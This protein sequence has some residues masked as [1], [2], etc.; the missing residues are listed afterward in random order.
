MTVSMPIFSW[1]N[2]RIA[3]DICHSSRFALLAAMLLPLCL[4]WHH[5][6]LLL[7]PAGLCLWWLGAG[8]AGVYVCVGG[9]LAGY[10]GSLW[11]D[12]Q[13]PSECY[14]REV[15]VAGQVV[16]FVREVPRPSGPPGQSFILKLHSPVPGCGSPNR[17][18]V[19]VTGD[20][21]DLQP[22]NLLTLR[23]RLRPVPGQWSPGAIPEQARWLARGVH[24]R[25]SVTDLQVVDSGVGPLSALR[26]RLARGLADLDGNRRSVAVLQALVLGEG[27]AIARADWQRF[28]RLGISHAFVISGLHLGLIF[29]GSWWLSRRLFLCCCPLAVVYR[30][31]AVAPATLLAVAYAA[32]AGFSLPTQRALVMIVLAA[33]TRLL[34]WKTPGAHL[35]LVAG[36]LITATDY[37]AVLGSSFWLSVVATAVLL[38]VSALPAG[39]LSPVNLNWLLKGLLI[40][41][42]LLLLMAP[43]NL[44][45]FGQLSLAAIIANLVIV[46]FLSLL[47]IPLVLLGTLIAALVGAPDNVPWS[48]A[49]Y[50]AS[51]GLRGI[52]IVDRRV[53]DWAI[54]RSSLAAPT[55]ADDPV[56]AVLDVG[57]GLAVVMQHGDQVWVYDTGDAPPGGRTQAEKILLPYLRN[58]RVLAVSLQIISHPDRDHAGGQGILAGRLPIGRRLGSGGEPCR[59]GQ[60]LHD[61][62]RVTL[63]VLNGPGFD[64]SSSCVLMWRY[65]RFKVLLA[66]D[67][68]A[69]RERG[70]IQYWRE[71][72]QADVLVVAHHGSNTSTSRSFLKWVKPGAGIIS[73][74]LANRFGHPHPAV[75]QRL[76]ERG[77]E[78]F[79]TAL[80]G[81][82]RV[83]PEGQTP[84]I[85]ALRSGNIPYWLGLP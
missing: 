82:V 84:E 3:P 38:S 76:R 45:W 78:V 40:Q 63:T 37:Y 54:I 27:G 22:G 16:S 2:H 24:G 10:W 20:T 12:W 17:L 52:E 65:G 77:V 81:T 79:N 75:L 14:R 13:I 18:A 70:L 69:Q 21:P 11:A 60:V 53:P 67:I 36:L 25:I 55:D 56:L 66:G 33:F 51:W 44:L 8:V 50:A 19:F 72:L 41:L 61:R 29:I 39:P 59:A 7:L 28:R 43:L 74:G 32:L 47:L 6:G 68:D 5:G 15:T 80:S 23:G 83:F 49:Q 26:L 58:R 64:N 46:P 34:G 4:P 1:V 42:L 31:W 62:D 57:Q 85:I 30:D 48:M 71:Q 73:S 9:L 35:L